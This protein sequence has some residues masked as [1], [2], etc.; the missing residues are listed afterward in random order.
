MILLASILTMQVAEA[1]RGEVDDDITKIQNSV[2]VSDTWSSLGSNRLN[3]LRAGSQLL[4]AKLTKDNAAAACISFSTAATTQEPD[5][6][7]VLPA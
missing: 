3:Q 1:M 6:S 7:G 4:P 2:C 5:A